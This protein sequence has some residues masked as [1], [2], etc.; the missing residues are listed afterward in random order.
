[1][2][3][4]KLSYKELQGYLSRMLSM[5]VQGHEYDSWSDEFIA[6]ECKSAYKSMI[7]NLQDCIIDW[8]NF[9]LDELHQL[10][11]QK[12]DDNSSTMLIPLY[13]KNLFYTKD[14]DGD[15]RGGLL[16]FGFQVVDGHINIGKEGSI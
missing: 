5:F 10:G 11:F 7:E 15:H 3:K 9:T 12:W 4:A 6:K 13:L 16:A 1:M 14:K 8:E 2:K